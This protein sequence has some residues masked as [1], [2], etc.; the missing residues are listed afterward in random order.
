[1]KF[2]H[3]SDLHIGKIVNEYNMIE[4]QRDILSQIVDVTRAEKPNAVLIA[5]D[6]YDK[7]NPSAE[8][9]ECFDKFL[10]ALHGLGVNIFVISG[11]HDSAER[12]SFASHILGQEGVYMSPVYDGNVTPVVLR[13]EIG[14]VNV[15]SLPFVKPLHIRQAFPDQAKD[16]ASYTDGVRVA[17]EHMGVDYTARNV[18][19]THQFVTG[20]TT[21]ES[22][23]LSVGGTDNVDASVMA[24]F[25][26]VALGH[27]HGAQS[28]GANHIRYCGTPL[29]Y[30]FS[31]VNHKKSVTVVQM[32][33]KGRVDIRT[34]PLTPSIDWR[35][36][37]GKYNDLMA[38]SYHEK[39][40]TNAFLHITLTDETDIP[41]AMNR[42]RSVYPNLMKLDYDNERTR[43]KGSVE[44]K[45]SEIKGKSPLELFAQFYRERNGVDMSAQQEQYIKDLIYKVFGEE[46]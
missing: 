29:K 42:L 22:E 14:E 15:Y 23:E 46:K 9:V 12:I 19:I 6:V 39:V 27:I 10:C 44:S 3:L 13:D 18:L 20:A 26:Y 45:I 2:I 24:D 8:A 38:L 34:M 4:L 33:E 35:E 7:T 32:G 30:S 11:N 17:I 1:M 31:E 36:D 25:D 40:D 5:G 28:V 21:C 43:A 37:K 16:I 41:N